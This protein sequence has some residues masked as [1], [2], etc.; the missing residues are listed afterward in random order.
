M[1]KSKKVQDETV[2]THMTI[3]IQLLPR[4]L[5][6]RVITSYLSLLKMLVD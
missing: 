6:Q 3:H 1:S 4:V 5:P 2:Q